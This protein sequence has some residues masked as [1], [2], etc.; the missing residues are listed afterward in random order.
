MDGLLL[1]LLVYANPNMDIVIHEKQTEAV[2]VYV[3]GIE[4]MT[5][6]LLLNLSRT[7]RR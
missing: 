2:N 1:L 5:H 7:T 6:A 4:V 3:V